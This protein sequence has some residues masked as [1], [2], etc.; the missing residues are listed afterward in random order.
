MDLTQ[1]MGF[2]WP[3]PVFRDHDNIRA[4]VYQ[5]M[6]K[7]FPSVQASAIPCRYSQLMALLLGIW[8]TTRGVVIDNSPSASQFSL[9]YMHCNLLVVRGSQSQ[10]EMVLGNFHLQGHGRRVVN[11]GVCSSG[12]DIA[13]GP[14]A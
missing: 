1:P 13:A 9:P 8:A 10:M 2:K 4:I 12:L 14:L 5:L 7:G 11:N 3:Q 6:N